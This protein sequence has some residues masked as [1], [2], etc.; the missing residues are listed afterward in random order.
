M[1][2]IIYDYRNSSSGVMIGGVDENGNGLH[3]Q[4]DESK[5]GH[6]KYN[7]GRPC[8]GVWV[9]GGVEVLTGKLFLTA[10]PNRNAKTLFTYLKKY[11][12]P[13]SVITVDSWRGYRPVDFA[14][15][16]WTYQVV[17]HSKYWKDPDTGFQTNQ[18]EGEWRYFINLFIITLIHA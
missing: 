7:K 2:A 13:G 9:L 14:E 18:I 15:A 4:V 10:V 5:F 12:K 8:K 3:I 1:R 11:I 6:Q 16:G 17:N